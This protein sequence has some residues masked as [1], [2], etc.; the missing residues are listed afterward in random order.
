MKHEDFNY[1]KAPFQQV[2]GLAY[3]IFTISLLTNPGFHSAYTLR[4]F[5]D[6]NFTLGGCCI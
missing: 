3:V 6:I 1:S 2:A 5:Q 4:S